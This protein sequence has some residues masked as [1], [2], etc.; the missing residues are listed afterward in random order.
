MTTAQRDALAFEMREHE[1]EIDRLSCE[2][3]WLD[4]VAACYV[5]AGCARERLTR[6]IEFATAQLTKRRIRI[7]LLTSRLGHE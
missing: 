6:E 7:A 2:L 5:E 3:W 4:A 1:R